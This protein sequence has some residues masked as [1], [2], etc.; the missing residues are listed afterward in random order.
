M[1]T[2]FARTR[3]S[4]TFYVQSIACLVNAL[5]EYCETIHEL[6]KWRCSCSSLRSWH[7]CEV[8]FVTGNETC[9]KT[10]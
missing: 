3:P 4:V 7:R 8:D 5:V 9:M 1:A 10:G 2:L 6:V